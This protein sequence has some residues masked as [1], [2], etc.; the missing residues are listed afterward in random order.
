MGELMLMD[1]ITEK[2][3]KTKSVNKLAKS[4][5]IP[6]NE[7]IWLVLR[8]QIESK[9]GSLD[10]MIK[11]L[12]LEN[13]ELLRNPFNLVKH[14]YTDKLKEELKKL[15][16][17]DELID[18]FYGGSG[19]TGDSNWI[20]L[21]P[22][23]V[24]EMM[25]KILEVDKDSIVIDNCCGAG[26]LLNG[27]L[28]IGAGDVLGIEYDANM[29]VLAYL[30]MALRLNKR[31]HIIKGDAFRET[32]SFKNKANTAIINPPYNYDDKGMPFILEALNNL[33]E[34]GRAAVIIQSSAGNGKAIKT[35]EEILKNHSLVGSVKMS[36][37]LFKPFASVE[38]HIYFFK[39]HIPH[40]FDNQE[41]TFVDFSDDGIKRTTRSIKVSENTE[42]LYKELV[43]R[44]VGIWN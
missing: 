4:L 35:N 8:Y 2:F 17:G 19:G 21:T 32:V 11:E 3:D 25:A 14:N 5:Q 31:P 42:E 12:G 20:V 41:V 38:T 22:F 30:S 18:D 43:K 34:G 39:A 27:A 1:R 36:V 40:D 16:T 37:D 24:S 10:N 29:W 7:M 15:L 44:M 33:K 6:A 26:A 9:Y 23:Y 28:S 13:E